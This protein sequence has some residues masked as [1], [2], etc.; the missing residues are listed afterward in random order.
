MA[1]LC[2]LAGVRVVDLSTGI[3]GAYAT[4]LLAD[5]GADVV[6][7]E[8]PEGDPLRRWTAPGVDAGGADGA[9]FRFLHLG[10]RSV[11][12]A[13]G[14]PEVEA[15]VRGADIV[16]LSGP[17][18]AYDGERLAGAEP[19][20]VVVSISPW[21]RGGSWESRPW[22]ELTVQAECG[23]LAGRGPLDRPPVQAG[24]RIAEWAAGAYAAPAAL[25]A[26]RRA[27]ATGRGAHVD[28]AMVSV[29]CMCTN[30]F[31]DL[32]YRLIGMVPPMPARWVE[33]PSIEPTADGWVG[34]NTNA[35]QQFHD[36]CL[37]I[38]R[39]DFAEDPEMT[40]FLGRAARA[41][42]WNEA[43]WAWTRRHTTDEIVERAALLRIPVAPI[44]NGATL[45]GHPHLVARDVYVSEPGGTFRHPRPPF[46]FDGRRLP[47]PRRMAPL[48]GEHTG[49]I[50]PHQRPAGPGP[51][52][53]PAADHLPFAGLKVLDA[54]CWWAGPAAT[55]FLA[56]LGAEV[57]HLESIQRPDGMRMAGAAAFIG[58]DRWWELSQFF[59][60]INVNKAGVTLDLSRPAGRELAERLVAWADV[61]V[62]NYTPRVFEQFGLTW[63][64]IRQI[65]PGAIFVRMPAFG[66]DGPWRDRVGFA[67]TVEQF[68]GLAWVT[69][70]P[71]GPPLIPRGP[72]DPVGGMHAAF[73][74][75][76]A[77]IERERTGAG[78]LVEVPLV[79]CALNVAAEQV[80]V[81]S[82]YGTLLERMGN[83]SWGA[84][85]QGVYACRGEEAWLALSV[86]TDAQWRGLRAALG[87][88]A[89]ARD[90]VLDGFPGR[91]AA[92][93]VLDGHLA[94]WAATVDLEEAVARLLAHG[95]PA[96]AAADPRTIA[97]HPRLAELGLFEPVAHPVAGEHPV[98]VVPLRFPGVGRW[99]R[100]PAPTLGQHNHEVLSRICGLNP[101]EIAALEADGVIG[102]RPV[103]L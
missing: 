37:L 84:A 73:A 82:A 2:F 59:L 60:S 35:A 63:D 58:R 92:H 18:F 79:E 101:D 62:E 11:V 98:M 22:S 71:D 36:F 52:G 53:T 39:P 30:L 26:L 1:E 89:W 95:V 88:P 57:V 40:T 19:G 6:K 5:A 64:A 54:T 87:D 81:H 28:V 69:G 32:T 25:A 38:E 72:C 86:L 34:F 94:A 68:S 96:A 70:Y 14:E 31:A 51:Q 42:E 9:L 45:P 16:V 4:K 33:L 100:E 56:G 67:Q 41:A 99:A 48:L 20:L 44:G 97:G 17:P 12:G 27:R 13:P 50:E 7:V 66:L 24:G 74:V 43:V 61:V 75:Q 49:R 29:M 76:L 46:L 78:M 90:P 91:W 47:P 65:N 80:V 85:P 55:Q 3:A 23:S 10:K 21:G 102:T 103:G 83:R 77:L 15:L 8:G 93:D